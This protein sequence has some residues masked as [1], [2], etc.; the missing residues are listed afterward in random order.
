MVFRVSIEKVT[1]RLKELENPVVVSHIDA[2]GLTSGGIMF[3][4]L[5]LMGKKPEMLSLRQLDQ[6]TKDDVPWDRDLVFLDFGSGQID[7]TENHVI[8][9]HHQPI[10]EAPYQ[11]NAHY[12][13]LDG[14]RDISASG[15]AYLVS[16][17]LIGH[18][19]LAG[20]AVVGAMGD[21]VTVPLSGFSRVPLETPWVKAMKGLKYFGRETRPISVMM[22]YASDPFIPGISGEPDQCYRFLRE[23]EID[24]TTT[25]HKLNKGERTKFND[26]LIK[27]ASR[28]GVPVHKMMGEYYVLPHMPEGTEMRDASEFSTLLNACGRHDKPEIGIGLV[29]GDNVYDDAKKLL[30][31]HRR[32]LSKG[33]NELRVKGT[34][35]TYK[36]FSLFIADTVKPTIVGIIAG[37]AI[38]SRTVDH[39]KPIIALSRDEEGWKVSGRGTL[40]LVDKGLNIGLAM[41]EASEGFGEGG[42]HDVAAGA[43]VSDKDIDKFLK[44]LNVVFGRQLK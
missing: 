37:I 38:S 15:L 39:R 3:K 34:E 36:N 28:K 40:E 5:Q 25:Y 19:E 43:F 33:M 22:K 12:L 42:G 10:R 26:A 13:G 20:P 16:K 6:S 4:T 44:R 14:S 32:L 21:R 7:W 23:L 2:D 24:E 27:Y 17:E 29:I 9:D 35:D 8:I 18:S 41:R 30:R 11:F 31:I 1:S